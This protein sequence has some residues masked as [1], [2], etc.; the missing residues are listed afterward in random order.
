MDGETAIIK[1][2]KCGAKGYI[3][4]DTEPADLKLAFSEILN[5]GF[6][7]PDSISRKIIQSINNVMDEKSSITS[8]MS[9]NNNEVT[10][11]KLACS[12]KSYQEIAKEMCL[13]EKTVDGYRDSLF[14]KLRVTTRVGMVMYAIK[15]GVISL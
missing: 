10:F 8:F 15:N 3:L 14:K 12:E 2:I 4:K 7:Y 9:L 13:S 1:M 5:N 6:Y 11:L